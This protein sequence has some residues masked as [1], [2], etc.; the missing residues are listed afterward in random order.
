[1]V[2][3]LV[4]LTGGCNHAPPAVKKKTVEVVVTRPITHQV[5]D[6]E[7]FTG[8]LDAVNTVEIRPRVSGY[9]IYA[10][11][12][13]MEGRKVTKG[14]VLFEIDSRPYEVDMLQASANLRLAEA[15]RNLQERQVD[16]ARR[17]YREGTINREE[18]DTTVAAAEKAA[19][20]VEAQKAAVKKA[21]IY[22]GYTKVCSPLDGYV[23][24]RNVDPG[25]L[26]NAD[27]TMLTTVVND[28]P[29]YVYFDV[30]ER[31]YLEIISRKG[32]SELNSWFEEGKYPIACRLA[33]E[34]KF[35][36]KGYVN[37]KDNRIN[38]S[39][40]TIRMRG[41]FDNPD[42]VLKSGL[43]ARIQLPVGFPYTAVLVPEAALQSDQGK[44]FVWVIS[45]IGE[46][47]KPDMLEGEVEYRL[48]T[49]GQAVE[50][51]FRVIKEG[52]SPDEH[53]IESGMQQVRAKMKVLFKAPKVPAKPPVLPLVQMMPDRTEA[54]KKV[55]SAD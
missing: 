22:L 8:R 52:L 40:G 30:D 43:F 6:Q 48:V 10:L 25:N 28:D 51:G 17:L 44:K 11:D 35:V 45:K 33:H 31:S 18:Y 27:N 20:T 38:A 26:V 14:Q 12:P 54:S 21:E 55:A 13:K 23:S 15:E 49:V 5:A 19:A 41:S 7:E 36:H 42:G 4:G 46:S 9:I 32:A 50:G 2:A 34:D 24:R 16:R 47:E 29:V 1:V 37:F 3:L 39:T 53:V